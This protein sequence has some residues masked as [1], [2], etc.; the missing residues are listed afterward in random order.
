MFDTPGKASQESMLAASTNSLVA[1]VV[2]QFRVG[3]LGESYQDRSPADGM[4][5]RDSARP[6][7]NCRPTNPQYSGQLS[8]IKFKYD[9]SLIE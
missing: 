4:R 7:A 2:L 1:G 5:R 6:P 8:V 9:L 3:D